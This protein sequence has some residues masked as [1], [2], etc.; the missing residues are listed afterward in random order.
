ME[1]HFLGKKEKGKKKKDPPILIYGHVTLEHRSW[2][3]CLYA[4]PVC[5]HDE[6]CM[7]KLCQINMEIL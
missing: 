2:C 4:P 7:V 6:M 5:W 1:S 3:V